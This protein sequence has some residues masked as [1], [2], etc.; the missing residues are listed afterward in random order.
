[1]NQTARIVVKG[2]NYPIVRF[3]MWVALASFAIMFIALW[4]SKFVLAAVGFT[5]LL[6]ARGAGDYFHSKESG[7]QNGL[8]CQKCGQPVDLKQASEPLPQMI[9]LL[10]VIIAGSHLAN[11]R[12]DPLSCSMTLDLVYRV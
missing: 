5:L 11:F 9:G 4:L 2:S 7:R 3:F 6:I 1:M 8:R 10:G 12:T